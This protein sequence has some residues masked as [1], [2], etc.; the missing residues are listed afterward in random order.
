MQTNHPD[1]AYE[2]FVAEVKSRI[3]QAQY[4]ALKAVNKEQM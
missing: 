3:R 4:Q 1:T 2:Q